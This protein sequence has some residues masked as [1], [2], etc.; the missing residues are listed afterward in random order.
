MGFYTAFCALA[1][2][3][4]SPGTSRED[5]AAHLRIVMACEPSLHDPRTLPP[6][7]VPVM[8][9]WCLRG[10][11]AAGHEASRHMWD[12]MLSSPE[13]REPLPVWA[14]R[15]EHLQVA[16]G[17]GA[18]R[19]VVVS[20][21]VAREGHLHR[22]VLLP[23]GV[24]S[25]HVL[26]DAGRVLVFVQ[27]PKEGG[28][29]WR[30][31][32]ELPCVQGLSN[33]VRTLA[34]SQGTE[35]EVV[36]LADGVRLPLPAG[37]EGDDTHVA[38]AHLLWGSCALADDTWVQGDTAVPAL[39][40]V[41]REAGFPPEEA[42]ELA[43]GLH[44]AWRSAS[45]ETL[46]L[47]AARQLLLADAARSLTLA[48]ASHGARELWAWELA[49]VLC[50]PGGR[51]QE[52]RVNRLWAVAEPGAEGMPAGLLES[53]R[54]LV[55]A[56]HE[57]M[58]AGSRDAFEHSAVACRLLLPER[59]TRGVSDEELASAFAGGVW[60]LLMDATRHLAE[61]TGEAE[62]RRL[63]AGPLGKLLADTRSPPA[64]R[65]RHGLDTLAQLAERWVS[66]GPAT[67]GLGPLLLAHASQLAG[68]ARAHPSREQGMI[69]DPGDPVVF[70][71][72]LFK[73]GCRCCLAEEQGQQILLLRGAVCCRLGPLS[74][75]EDTRDAR[76]SLSPGQARLRTQELRLLCL[77]G[78]EPQG[79]ALRS[80]LEL[81]RE[82]REQ[83]GTCS[84]SCVPSLP[85]VVAPRW[86]P[87]VDAGAVALR[88]G[89]LSR[90]DRAAAEGGSLASTCCVGLSGQEDHLR[91]CVLAGLAC[92]LERAQD[93]G[94]VRGA[95]QCGQVRDPLAPKRA[96]AELA[97]GVPS[98][99]DG[100]GL[101]PDDP[102]SQVLRGEELQVGARELLEAALQATAEMRRDKAPAGSPLH[103]ALE[104]LEG[105]LAQGRAWGAAERP[106]HRAVALLA[107]ACKLARVLGNLHAWGAGLLAVEVDV[108]M[109]LGDRVLFRC[110]M[111]P[112]A[113]P[114]EE[115]H[116]ERL[117][118]HWHQRGAGCPHGRLTVFLGLSDSEA[119]E[120]T[121]R[122]NAGEVEDVVEALLAQ[123]GCPHLLLDPPE[124]PNGAAA[125]PDGE[126]G[127]LHVGPGDLPR[128]WPHPLAEMAFAVGVP[129]RSALLKGLVDAA[130]RPLQA[131]SSAMGALSLV[132]GC[133]RTGDTVVRLLLE[134]TCRRVMGR[135]QL[136]ACGAG[137]L[138]CCVPLV[139]G[140]SL[141]WAGD[142][143][144]AL[145]DDRLEDLLREGSPLL[146]ADLCGPGRVTRPCVALRCGGAADRAVS[147]LVAAAR[148]GLGGL[149]AHPLL[150]LCLF[151]VG[152]PEECLLQ[153]LSLDQFRERVASAPRWGGSEGRW[154]V[155]PDDTEP[156]MCLVR[157]PR[158]G[159]ENVLPVAHSESFGEEGGAATVEHSH[160]ARD[161]LSVT[162]LFPGSPREV[163]GALRACVTWAQHQ[164][165]HVSLRRSVERCEGDVVACSG[166]TESFLHWMAEHPGVWA[167][168]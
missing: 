75:P 55:Q 65:F 8:R 10:L 155:P 85:A 120:G 117:V 103:R 141:E 159:E 78:Q 139:C 46:A 87:A 140:P 24:S 106:C 96:R 54:G 146:P 128:L 113:D 100:G 57:L 158:E 11:D 91:S 40:H 48:R 80:L 13:A 109:S 19:E 35:E 28:D 43:L 127:V 1:W 45:P 7:E 64:K 102:R 3:A 51:K 108:R 38:D 58:A 63:K 90:E 115:P 36:H 150:R 52:R 83:E 29:R 104:G 157:L 162:T 129:A 92:A 68:W 16:R 32:W 161:R 154:E 156:R 12:C 30:A 60:D 76:P 95:L 166:G 33:A 94:V 86:V 4:A 131:R 98:F 122:L 20:L 93:A 116:R 14:S 164:A 121:L 167:G 31:A 25:F 133:Q 27:D 144:E 111:R 74:S 17:G 142:L 82:W 42:A 59:L 135:G 123:G 88:W 73:E 126:G 5:T 72:E 160:R 79:T 21:F 143:R 107:V 165:Q 49:L 18:Q 147:Q 56:A 152:P 168:Q 81:G 153:T 136:R 34:P 137:G 130:G 53:A 22:E 145:R 118:L 105:A 149:M 41:F 163:C 110:C 77:Q 84:A 99:T 44:G 61:P 125:L 67:V 124:E 47:A 101:G 39:C 66:V 70:F 26:P 71:E 132:P 69:L 97:T 2:A 9:F 151:L 62:V 134:D 50:A 138:L 89:L 119:T 23:Q 6:A 112:L 15:E 148:Q 114:H 37:D